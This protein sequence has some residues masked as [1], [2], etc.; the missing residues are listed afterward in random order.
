MKSNHCVVT[1]LFTFIIV[2]VSMMPTSAANASLEP[3]GCMNEENSQEYFSNSEGLISVNSVGLT[4]HIDDSSNLSYSTMLYDGIHCFGKFTLSY[5]DTFTSSKVSVTLNAF[6]NTMGTLLS[7]ANVNSTSFS[8]VESWW[9]ESNSITDLSSEL[10]GYGS[11][12]FNSSSGQLLHGWLELSN[13]VTISLQLSSTSPISAD[14]IQDYCRNVSICTQNGMSNPSESGLPL[15]RGHWNQTATEKSFSLLR[16]HVVDLGLKSTWP[17]SSHPSRIPEAI[18]L[19]K[20]ETMLSQTA[21]WLRHNLDTTIEVV[22]YTGTDEIFSNPNVNYRI[23]N[24]VSKCKDSNNGVNFEAELIKHYFPDN[25]GNVNYSKVTSFPE[26]DIVLFFSEGFVVHHTSGGGALGC[27]TPGYNVLQQ[28]GRFAYVDLTTV[29]KFSRGTS[30]MLTVFITRSPIELAFTILH[31]I[32]HS[33]GGGH[34]FDN[35]AMPQYNQ[36]VYPSY[37]CLHGKHSQDNESNQDHLNRERYRCIT[38]DVMSAG[39]SSNEYWSHAWFTQRSISQIMESPAGPSSLNITRVEKNPFANVSNIVN[40][41][42]IDVLWYNV[43]SNNVFLNYN[44]QFR[45]VGY[46]PHNFTQ[47]RIFVDSIVNNTTYLTNHA[48][49]SLAFGHSTFP[50]ISNTE[51]FVSSN[52]ITNSFSTQSRFACEVASRSNFDLCL[53]SFSAFSSSS[54]ISYIYESSISYSQNGHQFTQSHSC[55]QS[56]DWMYVHVTSHNGNYIVDSYLN[57]R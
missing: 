48:H 4:H 37:Y 2:S 15:S 56:F 39:P 22:R 17:T 54:Y 30:A 53:G 46:T 44:L 6:P 7:G 50:A 43:E 24:G 12:S 11:L 40:G 25:S 9:L 57:C 18:G 19:G 33:L 32:S 35:T 16:I 42:K 27:A 26:S 1:Y 52:N 14:V 3:E 5:N 21:Q 51:G 38:P 29:A 20:I 10:Y 55:S 41:F 36:F 45:K 28:N 49:Y 13:R 8:E 34:T 23:N 31:E 47:M